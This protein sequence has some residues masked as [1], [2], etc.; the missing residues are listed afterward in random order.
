MNGK[1]LE[2]ARLMD[3]IYRGQRHIYDATRKYYLF[4]RDRLIA[5]LALQDGG[6]VLVRRF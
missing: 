5:G 1:A 6:K 4:G 2:H 3:G